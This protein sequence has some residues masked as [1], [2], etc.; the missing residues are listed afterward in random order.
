MSIPFLFYPL[1]VLTS[2]L[3]YSLSTPSSRLSLH[4]YSLPVVVSLS[5]GQ[6]P[7]AGQSAR[8]ARLVGCGLPPPRQ[9]PPVVPLSFLYVAAC[10][11]QRCGLSSMSAQLAALPVTRV[12][13]PY[14]ATM[15]QRPLVASPPSLP[16]GNCNV[17]TMKTAVHGTDGAV[18][19]IDPSS[20]QQ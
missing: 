10:L 2:R 12:D 6:A 8:T 13:D 14:P 20:S 9:I 19:R 1:Y 11:S 15:P 16:H 18:N 7:P 17:D 5:C 4:I 3:Y